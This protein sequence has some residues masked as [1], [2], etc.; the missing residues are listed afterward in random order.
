MAM[1]GRTPARERRS[2]VE[3][4]VPHPVS[5]PTPIATDSTSE[6]FGIGRGE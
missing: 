6:G 2:I 5:A 1:L 4:G 3:A